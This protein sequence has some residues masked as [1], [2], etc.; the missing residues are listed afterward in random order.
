MIIPVRCFTCGKVLANKYEYYLR[1][2]RKIKTGQG[3]Q[4]SKVMYLTQDY[5]DKTPEG[6]VMDTLGLNKACCRRHMLTHVD[7]E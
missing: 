2:V 5:M 3:M 1:E 7:I 4:A 6:Q